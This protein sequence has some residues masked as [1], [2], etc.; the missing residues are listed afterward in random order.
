M[1]GVSSA[2]NIYKDIWL[3]AALLNDV[4]DVHNGHEFQLSGY[5]TFEFKGTLVSVEAGAIYKSGQLTKYYYTVAPFE[6][7]ARLPKYE[8]RSAVNYHLKLG[9]EYP[10]NDSFS[11]DFKI[12]Y[13]WLDSHLANSQMIDKKGYF[14]GFSG[15]TYH[16]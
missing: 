15:I 14:S 8:L 3:D 12:K 2:F 5:R 13:T 1:V 7:K 11:A 9:F 16:F 4:T 10:I 6:A